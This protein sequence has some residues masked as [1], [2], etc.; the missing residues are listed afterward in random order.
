MRRCHHHPFEKWS[1]DDY[2]SFS[3]FFSRRRTQAA[4]PTPS[5]RAALQYARGLPRR[6]IPRRE[7][8]CGPRPGRR[9][10]FYSAG[11]RPARA[12]ADWMAEPDNPFFARAL[13]NRYWKHFF[14]RGIVEPEDDM[15]QTNPPPIPNCWTRWRSTSSP[16]A[17][18]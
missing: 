14:S 8:S 12:L 15:R 7:K 5:A 2:Y 18:I 4:R 3:A 16:A 17:S 9:A 10:A 13:V 11:P 1:Q 6:P